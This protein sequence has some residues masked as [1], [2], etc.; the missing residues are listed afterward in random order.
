MSS[1]SGIWKFASQLKPPVKPSFQLTLDEGNTDLVSVDDLYFKREDQNPTGSV[2]D[3]GL[4]YQISALRQ[5]GHKNFVISSSGNAAISAA[6]YCR[7]AESELTIFVSPKIAAN[8]LEILQ[9][10]DYQI[11]QT[12]RPVSL[13]HRY[14]QQHR[15]YN[16]RP[17]KDELG[18]VGY[19]TIAF[20]L[21]KQLKT[22]P[23]S[24]FVPVSSGTLLV[25]LAQGFQLAKGQLPQ[26]FAVQP[27]T[28]H[29]IAQYYDS[30]FQTET[31]GPVTSI[32][33]KSLPRKKSIH[34][35]LA[36]GWV[37]N[38]QQILSAHQWLTDRGITTSYEGAMTLA[39]YFKA[40]KK[41]Q[42]FNQNQKPTVCLLTGSL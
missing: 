7:L 5:Q 21:L 18:P 38:N 31:S 32:V 41:H 42:R 2:K 25:G 4:S 17:S 11:I 29:P 37:V 28:I 27:S 39:G 9:S 16:L 13:A 33:A 35:L 22:I 23:Q 34:Q 14:A 1:Q 10:T 20:E 36:G 19:Q 8:K 26:L 24:I 6:A 12:E 40:Q 30:D 3:R 15:A